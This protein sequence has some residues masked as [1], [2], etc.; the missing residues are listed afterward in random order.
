MALE[1]NF[2]LMLLLEW[3][4]LKAVY[5]AFK[6]V[7]EAEDRGLYLK[8]FVTAIMSHVDTSGVEPAKLVASVIEL[9]R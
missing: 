6:G 2:D 9:F 8:E 4:A 3:N 1:Q 7:Q 5:A